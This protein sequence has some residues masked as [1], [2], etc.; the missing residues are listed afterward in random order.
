MG[1]HCT[2]RSVWMTCRLFSVAV[3]VATIVFAVFWPAWGRTVGDYGGADV[4]MVAVVVSAFLSG[5]LL[6]PNFAELR[7]WWQ[8]MAAGVGLVSLLMPLTGFAFVHMAAHLHSTHFVLGL[9]V[10]VACPAVAVVCASFSVKGDLHTVLSTVVS[11]VAAPFG[12]RYLFPEVAG[13]LAAPLLLWKLAMTI[14]LPFLVGCIL[15]MVLVNRPLQRFANPVLLLQAAVNGL[16][17]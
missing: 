16:V 8:P 17:P 15:N 6:Q 12:V 2:K 9:V 1:L 3:Q 5:C 13:H 4:P 7:T 14:L 11:T 10:W